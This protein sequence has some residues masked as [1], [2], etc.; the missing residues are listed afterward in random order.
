MLKDRLAPAGGRRPEPCSVPGPRQPPNAPST[1]H[2]LVLELCEEACDA[3]RGD[4][5]GDAGCDL[6]RVDADDLAVLVERPEQPSLQKPKRPL[7]P[8]AEHCVQGP[9]ACPAVT[10]LPEAL[11]AAEA[12]PKGPPR[13]TSRAPPRPPLSST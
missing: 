10:P 1:F 13:F 12:S 9:S 4:G 5:E 8:A 7:P 2:V 6:E 3:V 11:W